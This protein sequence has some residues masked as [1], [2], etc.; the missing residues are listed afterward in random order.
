MTDHAN[1]VHLY[2][3]AGLPIDHGDLSPE[4]RLMQDV[5]LLLLDA[6]SFK[7]MFSSVRLRQHSLLAFCDGG[8]YPECACRSS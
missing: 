8:D 3:V 5:I 7:Q 6:A 1:D 4:S 2:G